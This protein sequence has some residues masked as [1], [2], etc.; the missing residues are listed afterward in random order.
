M[1][2]LLLLVVCHDSMEAEKECQK[3]EKNSPKSMP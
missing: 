3:M 1:G 2:C